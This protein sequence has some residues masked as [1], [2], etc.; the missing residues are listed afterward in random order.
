MD[1]ATDEDMDEIFFRKKMD[2]PKLVEERVTDIFQVFVSSCCLFRTLVLIFLII[3][4]LYANNSDGT[5]DM[6]EI[7]KTSAKI[8]YAR[9]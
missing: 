5:I 6:E 8:I 7:E 9:E 4:Q 1:G 3:S 2:P